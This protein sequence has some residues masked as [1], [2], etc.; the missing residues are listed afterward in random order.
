[1]SGRFAL[2][3]LVNADAVGAVRI[4]DYEAAVSARV[5]AAA[6][7]TLGI[8]V[9]QIG[10]ERLSLPE[11]TLQAT[12][13]RMAEERMVAAQERQSR[14]APCGE[15]GHRQRQPRGAHHQA[16]AEQEAAAIE[17]KAKAEA[18]AIYGTAHAA[19]P[20]LYVYLR[21]LDVLEATLA[22]NARLVL[23]TGERAV[24]GAADAAERAGIALCLQRDR[25]PRP[26]PRRR[27][28]PLR[29]RPP[30]APRHPAPG[31]GARRHGQRAMTVLSAVDRASHA[32]HR[33]PADRSR[34]WPWCCGCSRGWAPWNRATARVI[35]RWG[36]VNRVV[37]G[38]LALAWPAPIERIPS[39]SPGPSG[40]RVRTCAASLCRGRPHPRGADV[41]CIGGSARRRRCRR[42]PA[43]NPPGPLRV[44]F[45]VGSAANGCLTGDLGLVHL[46]ATVVWT[47]DD[48]GEFAAA[49]ADGLGTI[50][51]ALE[52]AFTARAI[53]V[54]A[55]RSIESVLGSGRGPGRP[56][57]RSNRGSGCGRS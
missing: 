28:Q 44:A 39:S 47:V 30:T 54:S 57:G 13:A 20:G 3:D 10:M 1:M 35:V 21:S 42:H 26:R 49:G 8:E 17:A 36:P 9:V 23:S 52:R 27:R 18:A 25:R 55:R 45:P 40:R 43:A 48:P 16:G 29:R 14:R 50:S 38:G 19:D 31:G 33:H 37:E 22:G 51:Q 2:A 12:V 11:Q 24:P 7:A 56:G 6:G 32:S 41:H 5:T 4:S 34:P 15:R 46:T 53:A